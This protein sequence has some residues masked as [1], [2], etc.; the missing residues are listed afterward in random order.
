MN[1]IELKNKLISEL[2][3][4]VEEMGFENMVCVRK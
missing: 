3:V 1:L 4:L 2:V